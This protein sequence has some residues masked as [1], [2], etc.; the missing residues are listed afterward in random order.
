MCHLYESDHSLWGPW[1][2][3]GAPR[4]SGA[5]S[6]WRGMGLRTG[7]LHYVVR[8]VVHVLPPPRCSRLGLT[9]W[10]P[11]QPR[12]LESRTGLGIYLGQRA[13]E[14]RGGSMDLTRCNMS[15]PAGLEGHCESPFNDMTLSPSQPSGHHSQRS[16]RGVHSRL[17][18]LAT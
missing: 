16:G 3:P 14:N 10:I 11:F 2:L 6:S 17:L 18:S 4:G 5:G 1:L 15:R 12:L 7:L 9:E 13:P 8:V